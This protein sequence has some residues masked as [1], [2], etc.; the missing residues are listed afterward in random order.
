MTREVLMT[1]DLG[2]EHARLVTGD[3]WHLDYLYASNILTMSA[4]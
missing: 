4:R 1:V 2:L 3:M